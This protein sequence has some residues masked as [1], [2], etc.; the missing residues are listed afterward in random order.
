MKE[1][2][3]IVFTPPKNRYYPASVDIS[4]F[5]DGT[6]IKHTEM[7]IPLGQSRYGGPIAD[8][9]KGVTCPKGMTFA[10]QLDLAA[11]AP[12]DQESRLPKTGQLL[13]FR[14]RWSCCK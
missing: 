2:K 6:Y 10:A 13:F 14:I 4:G 5:D 1:F 11:I 8:L 3:T 9:P 12:F 7:E